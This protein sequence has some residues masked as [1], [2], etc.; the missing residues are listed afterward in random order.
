M[1]VV[2]VADCELVFIR[3][4]SASSLVSIAKVLSR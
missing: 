1:P 3:S 2:R 4:N